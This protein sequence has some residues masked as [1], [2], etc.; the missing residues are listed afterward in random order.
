M[1]KLGPKARKGAK[2]IGSASGGAG[3]LAVIQLVLAQVGEHDERRADAS[4]SEQVRSA[5]ESCEIRCSDECLGHLERLERM[6]QPAPTGGLRESPRSDDL[7]PRGNPGRYRSRVYASWA[8][9]PR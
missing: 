8:R 6:C 5:M 3:L 9:A 4:C 7:D 1:T 2:V